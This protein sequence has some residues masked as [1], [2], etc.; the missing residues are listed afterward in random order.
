MRYDRARTSL[1][2]TPPNRRRLRRRS[3]AVVSI[4]PPCSLA[5]LM[6]ARLSAHRCGHP[7]VINGL[8]ENRRYARHRVSRFS[9][10][11]RAEPGDL[12]HWRDAFTGLGMVGRG[13]GAQV[14]LCGSVGERVCGFWPS[15]PEWPTI[16]TAC[17]NLALPTPDLAAPRWSPSC[18]PCAWP[19][20]PAVLHPTC[21][22]PTGCSPAG[23]SSCPVGRPG[24][25]GFGYL[26]R[27]LPIHLGVIARR[28]C[29]PS[30]CLRLPHLPGGCSA[31]PVDSLPGRGLASPSTEGS[32]ARSWASRCR[33]R[34]TPGGRTLFRP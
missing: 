16:M 5:A 32:C 34:E 23:H 31:L 20:W 3:G 12:R 8:S 26:M 4:V 21:P 18:W 28:L 27:P 22:P 15:L 6:T 10:L 7:F 14:G 30:S 24:N 1:T 17:P 13:L 2:A 33:I 25:L 19:P 11:G 9:S 29:L